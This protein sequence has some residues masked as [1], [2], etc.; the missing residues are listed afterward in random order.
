MI[1]ILWHNVLLI[2]DDL[3][4]YALIVKNQ[5]FYQF[6]IFLVAKVYEIMTNNI[7]VLNH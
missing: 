6:K 1:P 2:D 3:V 4:H 5:W 7:L